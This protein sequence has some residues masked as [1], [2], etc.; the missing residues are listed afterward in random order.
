M[1]GMDR[2]HLPTRKRRLS[3]PEDDAVLRLSPAERVAMVWPITVRAWAFKTGVLDEPRLR[4]DVGR[5]I[6]GRR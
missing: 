2:A 5:V 6:R 4:R 3:D 1:K